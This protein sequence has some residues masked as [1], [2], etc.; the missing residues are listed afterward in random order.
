MKSR[1]P[2]VGGIAAV[3]LVALGYALRAA[4]S[5]I[6]AANA[7]TYAGVL[8]DANGP[9]NATHNVQI[10]L[11]DAAMA[12]NSLCQ[13][14]T[15]TLPIVD[16][17]FSVQ[18]PDACTAAVGANA[19]VWADVLVDGSDTGR[20]KLGAVPY[21]VEANHAVAADNASNPTGGLA[22]TIST[23][24]SGVGTALGNFVVEGN[25]SAGPELWTRSHS[26][27]FTADWN[28]TLTFYVDVTPVKTF[29]IDHPTDP[30]RFLVH[31]T[32]EG[33]ESAVY[34]RGSG[35][36]HRGVAEVALPAYFEA[37]TRPDG[38]T[39][40]VTPTFDVASEPVSALA[41]SHVR[42]GA[43]V[44]RAIDGRNPE[45]TFDWE[46]KALRADVPPLVAEPARRDVTVH[47]DGPY[48]YL[49]PKTR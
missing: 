42:G 9:V 25:T 11:F 4:A 28:G 19:N 48:R 37:A 31:S 33:P 32:L 12:G 29:V 17:H 14:T 13:S 2:V 3:V 7:L 38:R 34:Y 30:D 43:F 36:L 15:L 47:G 35:R 18:L 16:G 10:A 26:N 46:I 1:K 40:N 5:G 20:T 22:S 27:G 49:T 8:E 23:L 6:P 45:Q 24:Q 41:V 39:A 21:A 44:V